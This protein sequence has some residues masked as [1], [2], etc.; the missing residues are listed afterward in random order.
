MTS[1]TD[2]ADIFEQAA[3]WAEKTAQLTT[4]EHQ[5]LAIWLAASP[6]HQAA[7]HK[8]LAL[9]QSETITVALSHSAQSN[10][11]TSAA[12]TTRGW[13]LALSF[14]LVVSFLVIGWQWWSVTPNLTSIYAQAGTTLS[15]PLPDGSVVVLAGNTEAEYQQKADTRYIKLYKGEALFDVSHL[16]SQ[17]PFIVET[18]EVQVKVTGTRFAVEKRPDGAEITVLEGSVLVSYAE[19]HKAL[20]AGQR[21]RVQH[22]GILLAETL[23]HG[24]SHF[25]EDNWLDVRQEPLANVLRKLERQLNYPILQTDAALQDVTITGRFDM[26]TPEATLQLIAE[27]NQLQLKQRQGQYVLSAR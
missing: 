9:W 3:E 21:L 4:E 14:C 20:V 1:N 12:N 18:G 8:C 25:L 26:R 2:Q 27:V 5:Q 22:Q 24:Y 13:R 23:W 19:Q 7:Y 6:A 15:H 11:I 10:P 17:Q 16:S